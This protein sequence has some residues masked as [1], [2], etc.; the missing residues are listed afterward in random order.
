LLLNLYQEHLDRYSSLKEYWHTKT[1]IF[2]FQGPDDYLIYN[3]ASIPIKDILSEIDLSQNSMSFGFDEADPGNCFLKDGDVYLKPYD[4]EQVLMAADQAG[5]LPGRHNLSNI[6]A[7]ALAARLIGIEKDRI[8]S[9]VTSFKGLPHRLEYTGTFAG[10][11]FYNDSI[12]TIPEATI[13]ALETLPEVGTLIL[14][15]YERNLNYEKLVEALL[16]K[17]VSNIILTGPAGSRIHQHLLLA[18]FEGKM[19][20]VNRLEDAFRII[21]EYTA[22]GQICLLSPA[23]ASYDQFKNFEERGDL[24]KGLAEGL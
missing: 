18:G 19:F 2:R 10:I 7:A 15:G 21:P 5:N 4:K 13:Y 14:G 11:R 8:V 23:A 12:A 16:A 9:S 17:G 6:M 3:K 20:F 22:K 24:F 1:N